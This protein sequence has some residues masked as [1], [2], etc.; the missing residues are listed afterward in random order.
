MEIKSGI[1]YSA[2][3]AWILTEAPHVAP[4]VKLVPDT[5]SVLASKTGHT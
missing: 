5:F 1:A 4:V 3:E 2:S